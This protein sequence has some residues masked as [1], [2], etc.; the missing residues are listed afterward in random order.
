[1]IDPSA[2]A[3]R[4]RVIIVGGGFGGLAAAQALR[5]APVDV[6]LVDRANHHLFQPLLYQVATSILA[7]GD[8]GTPIRQLM[9]PQANAAVFMAEVSGVDTT[10]HQ[11]L[12]D[13]LNRRAVPFKYDYLILATG[14]SHN[15]FGHEEFAEF[16]PGLK[17]LTDATTIRDRILRAFE[18]AEEVD[19]PK[20]HQ[21][22]LTFVLVGGGAT[23]VEMAGSIAELRR[24]TLKM[25]FRRVD[26]SHAR[27]ILIE[28]SPRVLSAFH[29]DL[30]RAAQKRLEHLGVEVRTG[31]H[32]SMIDAGGVM[33]GDE[34]IASR[35]VIWTAGVKPS[36]ASK[37]LNVPADKAGRVV[38]Q[39]DCSVPDRP[40]VFVI[41][42]TACL[43][44]NGKP[45]PGVAQVALQ[46]GQ[47]VASVIRA[48]V[49]G[50]SAPGPFKYFDKGNMAVVGQNFAVM[51][52]GNIR[53]SGYFA[54]IAWA[55]IH[56]LYLAAFGNRISVV[57][58]W[59]WTYLSHKR[60]SR[61][62]LGSGGK[63]PLFE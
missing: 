49:E 63:N 50:H 4:P 13:Y 3:K 32:V 23:G 38:V 35:T 12:V 47:Y 41:G 45:L 55:L 52:A 14:A 10:R 40:G 62:I 59:I 16:A 36:P 61:L 31:V 18:I 20:M 33:I 56:V 57:T 25:E 24:F 7:P 53:M 58:Q 28:G 46:Q 19:D 39:P 30:S 42:D 5:R 2:P 21:D 48:R 27:I 26:P 22:L 44:A 43:E 17:Q 1:M 6:T 51:E 37:W 34:R 54:W 15:Y 60:G 11:V 8:I 9:A 29:L